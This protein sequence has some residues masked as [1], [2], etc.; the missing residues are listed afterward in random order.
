M[1]I[2]A[3]NNLV[4]ANVKGFHG[5]FDPASDYNISNF[6]DAPGSH[7]KS[8]TTATFAS[9]NGL[10]FHLAAADTAARNA[11]A[12]LSAD[13]D[14]AFSTDIDG[15][16]RPKGPFDNICYITFVM[17]RRSM[18]PAATVTREQILQA[19]FELVRR[20]GL[21]ALTARR[22]AAELGCSTQPVYTTYPSMEAL[23]GDVLER[24]KQT[25]TRY[26]TPDPSADLPFL[27]MGLGSLRFAQDEPELFK[28]SAALLPDVEAG[29]PPPD[30][31]LAGMRSD[32][33]LARLG[34]QQLTRIH[35]LMWFFSQGLATL[36][37]VPGARDPMRTAEEY[38]RLAG[39]AVV[40]LELRR[41]QEPK[42]S[43]GSKTKSRKNKRSQT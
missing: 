14:L 42:R 35:N 27:S 15:E 40:E 29:K 21:V 11:G 20:E 38:L 19:A 5:T 8:S 3:K 2:I 23:R 4:H 34:Q 22:V 13:P 39:Q 36:F 43:K 16:T 1:T 10:D 30:F 37:L 18:P 12:D 41:S 26:L 31:L 24:A 25:A 7:S 32:P 9:I 6:T 28:L 33:L 17:E